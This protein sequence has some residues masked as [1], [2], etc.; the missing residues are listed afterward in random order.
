MIA[1]SPR[2]MAVAPAPSS[3]ASTSIPTS[4]YRVRVRSFLLRAGLVAVTL[5]VVARL[6][7]QV[8]VPE[9][10]VDV[11]GIAA[12][13]GASNALVRPVVH[14]LALP[15][16][17][18]TLGLVTFLLNGALV[19]GVAWAAGQL[20]LGFSVG[21]YPP[22]LSLES[23]TVAVVLAAIVGGVSTAASFLV[24]DL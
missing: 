7:P 16:R 23:L 21:G 3:T 1:A 4:P 9:S 11:V 15:I 19:L 14:L 10:P 13:F 18:A 6:L 22:D 20:E 17:L 8:V 5:V 2:H 24:P 12:L